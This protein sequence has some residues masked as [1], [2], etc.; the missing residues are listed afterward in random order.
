MK[1]K[2]QTLLEENRGTITEAVINEVINDESPI[3]SLLYIEENWVEWGLVECLE[4]EKDSIKF[5]NKHHEEIE[6]IRKYLQQYW[7]DM[8]IPE[9]YSLKQYYSNVAF[10]FIAFDLYMQFTIEDLL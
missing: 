7:H 2:L 10:K 6:K 1:E 4:F 8:T 5:F 3:K 9:W